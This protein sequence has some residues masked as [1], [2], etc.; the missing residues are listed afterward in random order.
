MGN[1]L[2][3]LGLLFIILFLAGVSWLAYGSYEYMKNK[4]NEVSAETTDADLSES[5][6]LALAGE[7]SLDE[8]DEYLDEE[9]DLLEDDEVD[10]LLEVDGILDEIENSVIETEETTGEAASE[11]KEKLSNGANSL[12][13]A[14]TAGLDKVKSGVS[15]LVDKTKAGI[16]EAADK[17]KSGVSEINEKAK[18]G[19]AAAGDKASEFTEKSAEASSKPAGKDIPKDYNK[20]VNLSPKNLYFVIT[21]SFTI[22]ENAEKEVKAMRKKGYSD[23]ET[24]QFASTKYLSVS[25]GR[26]NSAAEARKMVAKIKK[27]SKIEAYV[28]KR[29]LK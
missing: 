7:S 14:G 20:V 15:E 6:D 28:H 5:T 24:I 29:R 19:I 18:A 4:S 22:A 21:G 3:L 1:L 26:F 10:E 2:R 12:A 25:V 17:T 27:D 8:E 23:A 13:S 16:S 9:E 11:I